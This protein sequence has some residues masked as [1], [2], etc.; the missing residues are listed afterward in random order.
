[1]FSVHSHLIFPNEAFSLEN[2]SLEDTDKEKILFCHLLEARYRY[3]TDWII[4]YICTGSVWFIFSV[5][6]R[7]KKPVVKINV[8]DPDS[9]PGIFF[10]NLI[11]KI[12][13]SE[14]GSVRVPL[15]TGTQI[16]DIFLLTS[17]MYRV[18]DPH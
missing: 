18:S 8:A 1:M 11:R 13:Q 9:D 2:I 6:R 7:I 5:S 4:Q 10:K 12:F 14:T 17:P 15:H 16:L 3:F